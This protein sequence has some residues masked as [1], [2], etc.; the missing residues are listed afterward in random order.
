LYSVYHPGQ[1]K[2][3]RFFPNWWPYGL[4]G[5]FYDYIPDYP[6]LYNIG[7]GL[8]RHLIPPDVLT[9]CTVWAGENSVN[10]MDKAARRSAHAVRLALDSGFFAEMGTH[11]QKFA[12]LTLGEIDRWLSG[13]SARIQSYE[14]RLVGHEEAAE[15]T[16]VRDESWISAASTRDETGLDISLAGRSEIPQELAVFVNE[17]DGVV[18]RWAAVPA[19]SQE[20]QVRI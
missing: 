3:E 19:I 6:A 15:R 20:I 12:A 2:W 9:G 8:P 16:K 14:P 18:Q 10:D 13:L 1:L 7:A 4:P 11:E 5:M 17:G